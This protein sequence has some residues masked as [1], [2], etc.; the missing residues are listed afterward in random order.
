MKTKGSFIK[1]LAVFAGTIIGVGIFGLPYV[2]LQTG[3]LIVV[4]Y[5]LVI[6]AIAVIVHYLLGEIAHDTQRIARIPGYAEEYLGIKAKKLSFIISSAGLIGAL[7]AYLILG[8]QFLYSFLS[9]FIGG[10]PLLYILI[11]FVL[12]AFLVYRGA[13]AIA[14]VQLFI[15]AIFILLLFFFFF[16]GFPYFN[17]D[18][19]LT[20][21]YQSIALPYGVILFSLWG[22]ALVPEVKEMV[23]RDRKKMLAVLIFGVILAAFC[24]L[25]FTFTILGASGVYTTKDAISGFSQAIGN[26]IVSI[27]FLFGLIITFTSFITLGLTLKKIFWYDLKLNK[28]IS[29]GLSCFTPLV[30]YILGLRNFIDV[31]GLTGAL[32][33]GI[34]GIIV[35]LIY[36][37]FVRVRFQRRAGLYTYLLILLL[38]AGM[39]TQ[40]T[41]FFLR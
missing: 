11:F 14:P 9:P 1:S 31:I 30:L 21:N 32:F 23:E 26:K 18:N 20:F 4:I 34:E 36:R 41:Y 2:A 19:L 8:G 28:H 33:L 5:F 3:F 24:Y 39:I 17:F 22:I 35:I 16:K 7:L 25:F 40:L 12:G 37:K 27:G 38:F 15:Q 29:W 10:T 6:G 13:E